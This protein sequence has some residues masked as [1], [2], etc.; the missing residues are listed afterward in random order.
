MLRE[1]GVR[2]AM[3][4]SDG[5]TADLGKLCAASGVSA[6]VEA[7]RIPADDHLRGAFPDRWLELALG[8]GEDYEMVF[9]ATAGVMESV[10]ERLGEGISIIGRIEDGDGSVKIVDFGRERDS[11]RLRRLG[12]FRG[13][14]WIV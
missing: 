1:L 14:A 2:C 6:V 10:T 8:G 11:G 12:P 3:D 7:D 4:V 5:L 13:A 9:T